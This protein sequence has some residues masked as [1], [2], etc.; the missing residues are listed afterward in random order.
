MKKQRKSDNFDIDEICELIV[1]GNSITAI[2]KGLGVPHSHLLMWIER[3]QDRSVRARE[4]RRVTA[5]LWDEQ[6]TALIAKAGNSL[7]L[8]KAKEIAHHYR[9][10]AS[11]ISPKIYGD[12]VTQELT[13]ANGG[14]IQTQS[15]VTVYM[16]ENARDSGPKSDSVEV[17]STE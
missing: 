17:R 16:P 1:A 2:A 12:K 6:A 7:D 15:S 11:K 10:R 14:P 3:D 9:W 13:G 4:A 5:Q 8:A